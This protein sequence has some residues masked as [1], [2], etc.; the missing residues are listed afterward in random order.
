VGFPGAFVA[1][2][3]AGVGA[4]DVD[5]PAARLDGTNHRLDGF[6]VRDVG[7]DRVRVDLERD[8][9]EL[10]ARASRDRDARACGRQ[11]AAGVRSDAAAA[12]GAERALSVKPWQAP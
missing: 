11:L 10:V 3:D 1:G 9:L 2:R 8:F 6:A 12:P 5:R 7:D 4:E